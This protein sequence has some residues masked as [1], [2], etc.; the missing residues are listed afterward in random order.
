[1]NEQNKYNY[2]SEYDEEEPDV[3]GETWAVRVLL[4]H[5]ADV[6]ARDD[7][8]STPLHIASSARSPEIARLLIEHGADVNGLDGNLMTPLHLASSR[9]SVKN[10]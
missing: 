9:V 2:F 5:G 4:E 8:Q 6:T 10:A 1:V 3:E 7:S